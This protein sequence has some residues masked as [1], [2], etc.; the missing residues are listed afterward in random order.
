MSW[1]PDQP[2]YVSPST[3]TQVVHLRR[4]KGRIIQDCDVYIG[5]KIH[6]GGWNLQESK[7]SN[8]YTLKDSDNNRDVV[9]EKYREYVLS[10]QNL[11]DSLEELRGKRLGCWCKPE[12]C[13]G[14][15]LAELLQKNDTKKKSDAEEGIISLEE[16]VANYP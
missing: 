2:R 6:I 14:D 10:R 13:H 1:P 9:L 7:W 5:R 8:P 15:V 16:Y 3:E 12:K 4:Y 11:L